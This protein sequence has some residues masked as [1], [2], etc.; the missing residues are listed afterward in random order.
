MS[1]TQQSG[2]LADADIYVLKEFLIL[3]A[4]PWLVHGIYTTLVVIALYVLC[5]G[6]VGLATLAYYLVQLP[7]L[8]FNPTDPSRLM[9]NMSIFGNVALRV[10]Y[11]ISDSVVVWRAWV[12]WPHNLAV[13]ALLVLC[14]FGSLAAV[15]IDSAF[16][17]EYFLGNAKFHPTGPKTLVLTLPLFMTNLVSTLLMA[18]YRAE[19]KFNLG[20]EGNKTTQVES[21][22]VLLTESGTIYC[23]LWIVN[24]VIALTSSNYTSLGFQLM[25]S[26]L[27]QLT[28][29]YPIIII[30]LVALGK[31]NLESTV[32]V[33][34]FSQPI[35]FGSSSHVRRGSQDDVDPRS[36]SSDST[37]RHLNT[38]TGNDR[39][40]TGEESE[41][42][43]KIGQDDLV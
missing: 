17:I 36:V 30:L 4:V 22:L 14:L 24:L 38:V 12:L 11:L 29:I 23:L 5:I 26:L 35:Q 27:P 42:I 21:I 10:N 31:A 3:T 18:I 6:V 40:F 9:A 32:T 28:A 8:G 13:R 7:T 43:E 20:I 37:S 16:T 15:A 41:K 25:G 19:I 39:A 1:S 2:P 33:P 34:T